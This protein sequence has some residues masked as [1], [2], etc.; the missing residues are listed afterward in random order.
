MK[1]RRD[2]LLEELARDAAQL[3]AGELVVEEWQKHLRIRMYTEPRQE[4]AGRA[5]P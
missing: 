1:A 3:H 2:L 4:T 5:P